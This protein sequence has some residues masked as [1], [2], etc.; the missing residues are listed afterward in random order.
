[1]LIDM[2]RDL[3]DKGHDDLDSARSVYDVCIL[4]VSI[5]YFSNTD[6]EIS[7]L[8]LVASTWLVNAYL[9]HTFSSQLRNTCRRWM[10]R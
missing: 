9:F 8:T 4:V 5:K 6:D 7:L 10:Q 3:L 2:A 1:M